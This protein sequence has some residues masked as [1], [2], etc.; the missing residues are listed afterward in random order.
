M[1]WGLRATAPV[2]RGGLV[3]EYIGEVLDETQM[4]VCGRRVICATL[5]CLVFI[6]FRLALLVLF[7]EYDAILV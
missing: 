5:F 3:I 7:G 1:G 6:Y 4:Q 2:D